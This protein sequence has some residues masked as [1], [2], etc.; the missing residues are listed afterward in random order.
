M[1]PVA[2]PAA[3]PPPAT[4][5]SDT[6]EEAEQRHAT[7]ERLRLCAGIVEGERA[8]LIEQSCTTTHWPQ[9]T[10]VVSQ[11]PPGSGVA[12]V[13]WLSPE[14]RALALGESC[15]VRHHYRKRAGMTR[16]GALE[17]N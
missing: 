13:R 4:E 8:R 1:P 14:A 15:C 11:G 7:W 9:E 12:D 17:R 3:A 16:I 10:I 6:P 2:A 5:P